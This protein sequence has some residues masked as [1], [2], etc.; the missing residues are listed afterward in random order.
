MAPI[1][2][3]PLRDGMVEAAAHDGYLTGNLIP[4]KLPDEEIARAL[5][6]IER[7][8]KPG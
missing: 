7:F 5:K 8:P 1:V 4:H 3:R 2:S 6:S